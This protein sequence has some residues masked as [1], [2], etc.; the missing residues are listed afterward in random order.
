MEIGS[1]A[2]EKSLCLVASPS[3]DKLITVG[4]W[5][6]MNEIDDVEECVVVTE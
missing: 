4:G 1:M 3:P 5:R 6:G 2:S